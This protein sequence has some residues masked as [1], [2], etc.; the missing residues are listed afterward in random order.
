MHLGGFIRGLKKGI[1]G[2]KEKFVVLL[3]VRGQHCTVTS[4]TV[5]NFTK[6]MVYTRV[7]QKIQK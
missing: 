5:M 1:K 3:V 6:E 7:G 4:Y 2:F